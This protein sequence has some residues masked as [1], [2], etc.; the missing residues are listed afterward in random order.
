MGNL[1][2]ANEHLWGLIFHSWLLWYA[3][4][5]RR[6]WQEDAEQT[7]QV[8]KLIKLKMKE[9]QLLYTEFNLI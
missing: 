3:Y 4:S 9:L 2:Q 6:N 1:P 5:L 7:L 8:I